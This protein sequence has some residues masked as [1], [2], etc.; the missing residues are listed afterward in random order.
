MNRIWA[1]VLIPILVSCE[2][3]SV[4]TK[5]KPVQE[6]DLTENWKADIDSLMLA[7]EAAWNEGDLEKFMA[8]YLKSDSM[9][10]IGSSGLNYG[11]DKTLSNYQ[12]SYPDKEAMGT[13]K[14]ENAEYQKLGNENVLIIGR[15]NLYRTEDTLQGSYSLNWQFVD[16]HWKIIADHSS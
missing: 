4:E 2:D 6:F 16:G 5:T 10:F 14:F 7:Q 15:W 11:W 12:K 1:F 8:P 3:I 13:L 9:I